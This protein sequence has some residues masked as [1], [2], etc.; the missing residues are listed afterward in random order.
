MKAY[1]CEACGKNASKY[2]G[3][4]C[5]KCQ[6]KGYFYR[7][8]TLMRDKRVGKTK[9]AAEK[10]LQKIRAGRSVWGGIEEGYINKHG[11]LEF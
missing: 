1:A 2:P 3:T 5:E 4:I 7:W 11:A 10:N 6:A 9:A 8:G